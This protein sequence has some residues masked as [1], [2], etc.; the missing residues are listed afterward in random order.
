[1]AGVFLL[2]DFLPFGAVVD[3]VGI[4]GPELAVPDAQVVFLHERHLTVVVI[5]Q[6]LFLLGGT[7]VAIKAW[8]SVFLD[9]RELV[10]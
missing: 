3:G 9:P 2:V 1:M 8:E 4:D 6:E 7:L 10:P 5:A